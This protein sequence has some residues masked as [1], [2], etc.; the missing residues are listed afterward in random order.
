MERDGDVCVISE[1]IAESCDA[2]HL[3]PRRKGDE[4]LFLIVLSCH[5]YTKPSLVH[6]FYHQ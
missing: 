6:Q 4:V 3:I 5:L 2:A 1:N